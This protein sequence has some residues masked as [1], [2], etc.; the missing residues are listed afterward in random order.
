MV[1]QNSEPV[2]APLPIP[3]AGGD[4]TPTENP[5]VGEIDRLND[6]DNTADVGAHLPETPPAPAPEATTTEAPAPEAPAQPTA[7]PV[8]QPSAE[9]YQRMQQQA[10]QY[11]Q[12]QETQRLQQ[13]G[14]KYQQ[15]LESQGY[16]QDQAQQIAH[17]YMQSRQSQLNQSKQHTQQQQELQGKQ[18]AAEHFA[19][20]FNLGFDDLATLRL[21]NSPE[22]M[23]QVAKKISGD[24][25]I[26]NELDTLKKA[27]VPA[28]QFDNSQGAPE[29]A[30]NDDGWLDRYNNGDRSANAVAAAKKVLGI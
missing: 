21:S 6:Q 28:Q 8:Q 14:Q 17:Q 3:E 24:K 12:V 27:Q 26:R 16:M 2:Q 20:Q 10:A 7:P 15:Q 19:R 4:T 22:Q 11:Q 1:N 25:A 29:V 13:E 5:I 30:S 9:E 18:A 23:E